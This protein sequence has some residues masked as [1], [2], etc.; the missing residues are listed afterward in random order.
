MATRAKMQLVCIEE[1]QFSETSTS[2]KLKFSA[3]YDT[4]I[5]EDQRFQKATP[6]GLAEFVIDNPDALAQ[7]KPGKSYYF[8]ISEVPEHPVAG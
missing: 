5:P 7:F 1:T 4:S 3:R 6:C 2:R 8:D